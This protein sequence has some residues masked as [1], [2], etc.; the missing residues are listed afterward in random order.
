MFKK[1]GD[2]YQIL[3]DP[4]KRALYDKYGDDAFKEGAQVLQ[5]RILGLFSLY[6]RSLLTLLFMTSTEMTPSR[7]IPRLRFWGWIQTLC[8]N[9]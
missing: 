8:F 2:A 3:S 1:V 9:N 7:R 4:Q 5:V 6:I